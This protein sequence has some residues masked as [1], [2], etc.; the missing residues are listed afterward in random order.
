MVIQNGPDEEQIGLIEAAHVTAA[1]GGKANVL[2][3]GLPSFPILDSIHDKFYSSMAMFCPGCKISQLDLALTDIGSSA[4]QR[5]V[6]YLRAHPNVNYIAL[7][8]DAQAIGLPA[9]LKVAGIKDVQIVG[10]APSSVNLQYIASAQQAATVGLPYY[11]EWWSIADAM[12]RVFTGQSVEHDQVPTPWVLIT[13]ANVGDPNAVS[14][15][16]PDLK[17]QFKKLWGMS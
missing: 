12:A 6:S 13:K 3:I 5:I 17:S 2:Y 4:P 7:S 11:E 9:A 14:P 1:T 15:Y 16:V 10:Y 8:Y